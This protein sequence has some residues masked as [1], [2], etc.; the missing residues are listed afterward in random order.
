MNVLSI[1]SAVICVD[2][3]FMVIIK[4][5]NLGEAVNKWYLEYGITAVLSDCLII[6]LGIMLAYFLFPDS[7]LTTI[8]IVS[9]CIQLAH[10][11]LFYVGVIR[12][13]PQGTNRIIDLFKQYAQEHS[14]KILVADSMMVA[15]T[16]I[17]ADYL[18]NYSADIQ[19]FVGL[20]ALYSTTYLLYTKPMPN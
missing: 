11:Y 18:A 13:L 20:L 12:P 8:V 16:V 1:L 10:D 19:S 15:S 2:F 4:Y 17:L 5:T 6:V 7:N 9:L 14:W 3:L